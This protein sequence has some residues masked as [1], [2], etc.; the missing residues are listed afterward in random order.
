MNSPSATVKWVAIAAILATGLIHAGETKDAF[1]DAT[2]KGVLFAANCAGA[3]V[4][5]VG[6]YRN[7]L[8]WG[9]VLGVIVAGGAFL[10][11]VVSR[12]IGLPG[13]PAANET[14]LEPPGVASL[15]VEALFV[16]LFFAKRPRSSAGVPEPP[17]HA[18]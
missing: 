13:L 15:V 3:L 17:A 1:G 8:S 12:T 10:G 7:R 9:W 4:A 18:T 14:W 5:A 11:Y 6:I 16:V 2:Y